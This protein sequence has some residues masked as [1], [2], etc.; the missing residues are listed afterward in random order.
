MNR[1][2]LCEN[3]LIDKKPLLKALLLGTKANV[4]FQSIVH[5]AERQ[6]SKKCVAFTF[7]FVSLG[8]NG[9]FDQQLLKQNVRSEIMTLITRCGPFCFIV[10]KDKSLR[11]MPDSKQAQWCFDDNNWGMIHGCAQKVR[12]D[13]HNTILAVRK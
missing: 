7:A 4:R 6:R 5:I 10:I 2:L 9:P 12:M 11:Q 13:L 3:V 1:P 8:V